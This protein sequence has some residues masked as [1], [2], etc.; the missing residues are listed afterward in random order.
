MSCVAAELL[1]TRLSAEHGLLKTH[2]ASLDISALGVGEIFKQLL[3]ALCSSLHNALSFLSQQKQLL[4]QHMTVS[5]LS[6][7]SK[8]YISTTYDP[9]TRAPV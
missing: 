1:Q 8:R 9:T 6:S 7:F 2:G 4:S 5:L 3:A